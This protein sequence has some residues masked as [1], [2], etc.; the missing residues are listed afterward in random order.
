M[1][2][3]LKV[4]KINFLSL[5]ALPFFLLTILAQLLMKAV[6]KNNGFHWAGRSFIRFI[7]LKPAF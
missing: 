6:Q 3:I 2:N 1:A 4:L 5:L 7:P